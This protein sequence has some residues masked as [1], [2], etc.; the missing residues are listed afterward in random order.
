M[1]LRIGL[2]LLKKPENIGYRFTII[3]ANKGLFG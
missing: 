1:V 2:K 3:L